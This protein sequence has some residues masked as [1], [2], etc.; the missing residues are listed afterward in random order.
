[1]KALST[2]PE[3]LPAAEVASLS[4]AALTDRL[5]AR[6]AERD[7]LTAE[8]RVLA[9]EWDQ[10]L[11]W[12]GDAAR[13]GASW[14]AARTE[15][16]RGHAAAELKVARR[17]RSMPVVAEA[18]ASGAL[19]A[20]KVAVLTRAVDRDHDGSKAVLFA[21]AEEQLVSDAAGLSVDQT[22]T[23]VRYWRHCAD[24]VTAS[25]DGAH[26]HAERFLR[27]GRTFD[28][29]WDLQ[30]RLEPLEGEVL[31]NRLSEVMEQIY[32]SQ[33]TTLVDGE[34]PDTASQRRADALMELVRAAPGVNSDEDTSRPLPL[35]LVDVP[36]EALEDRAGEPATLP[37]GTTLAPETLSC[38][39][40]EAG[41]AGLFTRAGRLEIDLGRASYTPS[42]AQ[43]R[44]LVRRD[45]GCVFPGCDRPVAW[46]DAHHLWHWE[47][48]GV[49]SLWNLVLLCRFHHHAVHEG[50][51]RLVADHQGF[52]HA[53]RPDGTP[54]LWPHGQTPHRITPRP[55]GTAPP[56]PI[57]PYD[58]PITWPAGT[59]PPPGL[60]EPDE[61]TIRRET[62]A[63]T[64]RRLDELRQLRQ[65]A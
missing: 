62:E 2:T 57:W 26:H 32:R 46:C 56:A 65:P 1:M 9:G 18:S 39:A 7:A 50:K 40:C 64:R 5:L 47:H 13:S 41:L 61:L 30:G 53:S 3:A 38:L 6:L 12:A 37:D 23:A 17:L 63:A 58:Q 51:F 8:I 45:R 15:L 16:S 34:Q 11:I 28:G 10:R 36:L 20:E 4:D 24:D 48:G 55:P 35:L 54:I 49:T 19:G 33:R 22:A 31:D 21:Q 29:S 59:G 52:L 44:A 14:L 25:E 60:D 43:R 42:R 27:L